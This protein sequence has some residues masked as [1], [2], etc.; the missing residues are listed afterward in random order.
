MFCVATTDG[1]VQDR[2]EGEAMEEEGKRLMVVF[3]GLFEQRMGFI[4]LER[5]KFVGC[6][7]HFVGLS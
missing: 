6:K 3:R 7:F 2:G 4:L 1:E 5:L